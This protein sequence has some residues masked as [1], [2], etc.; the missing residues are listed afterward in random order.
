[1]RRGGNAVDGAV[2]AN[3]V[4]GVVL[5]DT[6]GPGGDLFALIHRPGDDMPRALNASGRAG[7][8][9]DASFLRSAQY[10]EIPMSS[11]WV[12]TIPG[13]VD[14]W[15]TLLAEEGSISLAEALGPAIDLATNGFPVSAEL[16]MSLKRMQSDIQDQ[17]SAPPL[18]PNGRP[19]LPGDTLRRPRLADTLEAVAA[20][21]R[22][23]FYSGNVGAAITSVT[24]G[25]IT[26]DDLCVRQAEWITPIGVDVFG[27]T[28]WTIP[29]NSQGYLTL[30][31]AWIFDQFVDSADP[32][33]PAFQ[34]GL[35]EAYRAVSWER[36]DLVADPSSAPLEDQ[37]L[38]STERLS[39]RLAAI[40]PD[41]TA[42][43]PPRRRAPGG[44]AFMCIRDASGTGV[45]LIQSNYHGIGSGWSAGDTGVFLHDRGSGF[46]LSAGHPNELQP[47]KRPLHT[48][49]PTLWT[50]RRNLAAILGTRGGDYQPQ[51]LVQ[52]A[53][54]LFKAGMPAG[55]AQTA[56]R[57][58]VDFDRR[59]PKR[60]VVRVEPSHGD[61][62]TQALSAKGHETTVAEPWQPAWGPVSVIT[63][64]ESQV[65]A[66]ADPRITTA[67]AISSV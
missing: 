28:G 41:T 36:N 50:R 47:G 40:N 39:E 61:A 67:A 10:D 46:D 2:A 17:A 5:P 27:V 58:R 54:N 6:C 9:V 52:V 44:T 16:S 42:G 19:P 64:D 43:W 22:E 51:F 56:P 24:G 66:A 1:M 65:A 35:I 20:G 14:G 34:H 4:L 26:P 12:I 25:A 55:P 21:G 23:A 63:V 30:A 18:Y 15:E 8:G 31:A 33:D 57:W 11:P 62:M 13:C 49:A 37:A 32:A 60:H 48:L 3:A 45:A 29:P 7:S 38:L 53:A 59:A